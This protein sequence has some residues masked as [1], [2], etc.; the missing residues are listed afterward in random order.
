MYVPPKLG[1]VEAQVLEG[2]FVL[3]REYKFNIVRQEAFWTNP[4]GMSRGF[5]TLQA[6]EAYAE[7][8]N[9]LN[10]TL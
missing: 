6:A 3:V 4:K 10:T 5:S 8:V 1:T 7:R 2:N 9:K